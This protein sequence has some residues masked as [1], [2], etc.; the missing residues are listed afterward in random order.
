MAANHN[1]PE[2]CLDDVC[3]GHSGHEARI[4]ELE[5]Q[6]VTLLKKM[7]RLY[8]TAIL[9]LGTIA[10]DVVLRVLTLAGVK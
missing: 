2:P 3:R 9:L 5:K 8:N 1:V 6:T 7:D 10:V 4:N